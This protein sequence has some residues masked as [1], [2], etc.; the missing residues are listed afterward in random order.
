MDISIWDKIPEEMQLYLSRNGKHFNKR[1]CEFAVMHMRG[2]E[3]EKEDIKPYTREQTEKMLLDAGFNITDYDAPYDAVYLA[4]M[5]K[6]D[7]M[8][9]SLEDAEHVARYI[10]D[11]LTDADGY[12]GMVF[13]RWIADVSGKGVWVDWERMV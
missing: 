7:Y 10:N 3:E 12:E 6:Y 8:G 2:K 5:A 11:T 13:N 1:L 4:N 9:S